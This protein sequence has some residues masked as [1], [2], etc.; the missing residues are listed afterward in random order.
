MRT[1][2][3]VVMVVA[4]SVACERRE[5]PKQA[6]NVVPAQT[7]VPATPVPSTPV[8]ET[9]MP[10]D[11]VD[12]EFETAR[13][14]FVKKDFD[15]A[16]S[17]LNDA[18][19]R[20][21]AMGDAAGGASRDELKKVADDLGRIA[22]DVKNGT[23]RDIKKFDSELAGVEHSLASH[24]LRAA[25]DAMAGR[26]MRAAGRELNSA[27]HDVEG[28]G[29]RMGKSLDATTEEGIKYAR[30]VGGKLVDGVEQS[31]ADVEKAAKGLEREMDKL[32]HDIKTHHK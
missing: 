24:H 5:E 17:E 30:T 14:N 10:V 3:A 4:L 32:G 25:R 13:E 20:V 23:I 21:T 12:V 16:A 29:R 15:G 31:P 28:I 27:A 26:D 11:E 8:V 18:A 6:E 9:A 22:G 1:Y 2:A 7:P 19:G